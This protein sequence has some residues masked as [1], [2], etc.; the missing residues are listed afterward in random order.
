MLDRLKHDISP[1][2]QDDLMLNTIKR[3]GVSRFNISPFSFPAIVV[4]RASNVHKEVKLADALSDR[5]P[6]FRRKGGGCSVF[7]DPGSLIVSA[8]FPAEGYS[9]I[10]AIFNK[11]N[12]WLI[13]GLRKSGITSVCH[14]G[15]SDI[16]INNKKVGGSCFYRTKGFAYFSASIIVSTDLQMLEK[17]LYHPPR[18]P[19]YR[20]GRNHLEFVATLDSYFKELNIQDLSHRLK[21]NLEPINL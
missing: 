13:N 11:S 1:F 16:T 18:E 9:E 2:P 4:G 15:I 3:D 14:D 8:V 20:N 6:I 19:D 7:L 21:M 5:I 12:F 17:Y 10:K